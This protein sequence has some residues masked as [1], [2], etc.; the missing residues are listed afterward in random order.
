[1]GSTGELLHRRRSSLQP[2]YDY[3]TVMRLPKIAAILLIFILS[4]IASESLASL[5]LPPSLKIYPPQRSTKYH[6]RTLTSKRFKTFTFYNPSHSHRL[7]LTTFASL[8]PLQSASSALLHLYS[9]LLSNA[10]GPWVSLPAASS[11]T[12][13]SDNIS[14]EFTAAGPYVIPWSFVAE[15]AEKMMDATEKGFTGYFQGEYRHLESGAVIWVALR[16]RMAAAA[17]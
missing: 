12:A 15:F 2:P 10:S 9:E 14:I 17:A 16:I 1:M 8:L 4:I 13:C 6:A 7:T 3:Q 11:F 5:I